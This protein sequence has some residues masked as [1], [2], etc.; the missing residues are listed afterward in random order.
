MPP[1]PTSADL[2]ELGGGPRARHRSRMDPLDPHLDNRPPFSRPATLADF[3]FFDDYDARIAVEEMYE[4]AA[5]W[6]ESSARSNEEGWFY[7]DD[8]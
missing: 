4:D 1:P 3:G 7:G 6:N 5:A 8:H 2:R